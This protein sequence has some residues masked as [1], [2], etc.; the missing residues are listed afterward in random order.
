MVT[1]KLLLP[2]APQKFNTFN[3]FNTFAIITPAREYPTLLHRPAPHAR[4]VAECTDATALPPS[5]LDE[6]E[7]GVRACAEGRRVRVVQT[8]G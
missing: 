5:R 6:R 8:G 4:S 3:T 2:P 7:V 1:L